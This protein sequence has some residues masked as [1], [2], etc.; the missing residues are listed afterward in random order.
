MAQEHPRDVLNTYTFKT[1]RA[2]NRTQS[3]SKPLLILYATTSGNAQIC[4]DRIADYA[5][6]RGYAPRVRDVD[7]YSASGLAEEP[8]VLFSVSTYGDGGAPGPA[9][10]FWNGVQELAAKTLA[11][12]RY[13]IY[14]IG[15]SSFANYCG[16]GKKL[17]A[18]LAA[19]GGVRILKRSENDIDYETGIAAWCGKVFA[20]LDAAVPA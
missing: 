18:E 19:K 2:F 11:S 15:D 20:A 16:F 8:V 13:S 3:M 1:T 12:L 9:A 5:R 6:E 14:A 4:A 7:G 17:D 10:R